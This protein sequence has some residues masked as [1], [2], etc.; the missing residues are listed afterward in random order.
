MGPSK[1][2]LAIGIAFMP[3]VSSKSSLRSVDSSKFPPV[4][5]IKHLVSKVC[6]GGLRLPGS[7]HHKKVVDF[8]E[9][10]LSGMPGLKVEKSHFEIAGWQPDGNSLYGAARFKIGNER[11]DVVSAMGYCL[12]TNGSYIS[13]QLMYVP[14]NVA[15]SGVNVKGRIV[16]RDYNLLPIPE[17]LIQSG[18]YYASPDTTTNGTYTRPFVTPPVEDLLASSLGGAAGYISAFNVSREQLE[19]YYSHHS[20]IHWPIPAIFTGAEQYQQI[21]AASKAK[22]KG[23]IRIDATTGPLKVPQLIATLPGQTNRTIVVAT[24]TDGDTHIQENGPAALLALARYFSA[25]PVSARLATIKFVFAA[26]HLAYQKDSD[27]TVALALD[28]TYDTNG[29]TSFVIA[30]EHLGAREVLPVPAPKGTYGNVLE[31][32]GEGETLLWAVGPV[33]PAIMAATQVARERKLDKTIIAPGFP[34]KNASQVPEYLSFGGIGTYYHQALVPTMAFI[35]G[36]WSLWAPGFG[37]DAVDFDRLRVQQMAIGDMI[38]RLSSYTKAEL[39]GNYTTYRKE[40][41]KG[42]PSGDINIAQGDQFINPDLKF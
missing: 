27:K 40:R 28:A 23:S 16:V 41:A 18:S 6:D 17:A 11:F 2:L 32:T 31:F 33:K 37:A 35:S 38:L 5:E 26:S 39:A 22:R 34:P 12:P 42:F 30:L 25:L 7:P 24:H 13:G 19:S 4:H 15:L 10:Q 8:I 14:N 36:P 3:L 9:C 20:G 1:L 29:T 21:R